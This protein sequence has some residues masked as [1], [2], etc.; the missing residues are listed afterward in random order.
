MSTFKKEGGDWVRFK[1]LPKVLEV[2][3]HYGRRVYWEKDYGSCMSDVY[4]E[5]LAALKKAQVEGYR[6]VIFRHGYSTSRPGQ[7]TA[8]STVRYLMRSKESSPY[9]VKNKCIQ[10][11]AVF[12]AVIK[13]KKEVK[14]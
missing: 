7:T 4:G 13:P 6:H 14:K 1:E 2:D 12:V 8:R 11:N 3:F 5:A 9:I 10:H